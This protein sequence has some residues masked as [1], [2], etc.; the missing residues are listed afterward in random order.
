MKTIIDAINEL[1]K[2]AN[3]AQSRGVYSLK[4]A[5]DIYDGIEFINTAIA[6]QNAAQQAPVAEISKVD[7]YGS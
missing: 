1:I 6:S 7:G 5:H 3:I 4:E 2:G